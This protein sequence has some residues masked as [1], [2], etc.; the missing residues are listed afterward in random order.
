MGVTTMTVVT[1][2]A[3]TIIIIIIISSLA[4]AGAGAGLGHLGVL[5]DV[6]ASPL[7]AVVA[8]AALALAAAA[9]AAS[10]TSGLIECKAFITMFEVLRVWCGHGT[11]GTLLS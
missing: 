5:A 2:L 3:S 11:L 9:L 1:G 8:L 7:A 6:M 4:G 10:L